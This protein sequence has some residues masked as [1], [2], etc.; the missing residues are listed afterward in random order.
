MYRPSLRGVPQQKQNQQN[1]APFGGG[2]AEISMLIYQLQGLKNDLTS[3]L[4]NK[5][6][7]IDDKLKSHLTR[8]ESETKNLKTTHKKLSE[9]AKGDKGDSVDTD[10]LIARLENR[11]PE[12]LDKEQLVNEILSKVPKVNHDEITKKVLKAIPEN[13]ASLKIIQEHF[14]VDPMSVIEQIM[15]MPKGKFKLK[16]ENIDGLDQTMNAFNSQ[17]GRGYLHGGGDTVQAGTNITITT[18]A[19]GQKQISSTSSGGGILTT[20]STVDGSNTSFIF[21]TATAQPS[22][23]YSDGVQYLAIRNSDG[24]TNW[25]WNSGTKTVTFTSP[26]MSPPTISVSAVA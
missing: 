23:V 10:L 26:Q 3:T 4:N 9:L 6:K 18:T 8:I 21:L 15:K 11:I 19:G 14:T 16:T 1:N 25:T 12:P 7:E 22:A 24:L 5:L 2:F 13:K 20:A 17:L